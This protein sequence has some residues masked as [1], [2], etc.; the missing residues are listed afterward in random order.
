MPVGHAAGGAQV[1]DE[2]IVHGSGPNPSE[3]VR[4]TYVVAF[5]DAEMVRYERQI[6]FTHSYTMDPE[7]VRRVR[8]G[9]L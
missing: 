6:G 8:T 2:W 9:E 4:K 5:R 1:H 7:V 3:R